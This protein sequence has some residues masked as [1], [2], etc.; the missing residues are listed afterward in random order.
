MKQIIKYLYYNNEKN[1]FIMQIKFKR[2]LEINVVKKYLLNKI[3]RECA[4]EW[5]RIQRS[6]I[7]LHF[8][9]N[10]EYWIA[11]KDLGSRAV[12]ALLIELSPI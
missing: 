7:K 11:K 10:T 9:I 2:P 4:I 5:H 12:V 6:L 8:G 1:L 3:H